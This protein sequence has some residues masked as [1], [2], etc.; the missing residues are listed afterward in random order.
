MENKN[1]W[2]NYVSKA[3]IHDSADKTFKNVSFDYPESESGLASVSVRLGQVRPTTDRNGVVQDAYNNVLL[4]A[5]GTKRKISIKKGGDYVQVEVT[6]EDILNAF[7]AGREAYRAKA[8]AEAA[9]AGVEP[10]VE[11]PVETTEATKT[12]KKG[13]RKATS[14]K[15]K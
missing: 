11:A 8:S 1:I 10:E 14:K 6:V 5:A 9:A 13:G 4:G 2:L 7:N 15:T 12:S 3:M